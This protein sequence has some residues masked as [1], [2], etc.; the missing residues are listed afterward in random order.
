MTE[1][2]IESMDDQD[3]TMFC[4]CMKLINLINITLLVTKNKI[5]RDLI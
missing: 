3:C 1:R 5:I 4:D 2:K